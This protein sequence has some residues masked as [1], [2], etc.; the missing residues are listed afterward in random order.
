MKSVLC[1]T[2]GARR[3]IRMV[4]I[5]SSSQPAVPAPPVVHCRSA[6]TGGP[7]LRPGDWELNA[8]ASSAA[9]P[10][11]DPPRPSRSACH[12][13]PPTLSV[14]LS[15]RFQGSSTRISLIAPTG[16][17]PTLLPY[18]FSGGVYRTWCFCSWLVDEEQEADCRLAPERGWA[19]GPEVHRGEFPKA[20]E[21]VGVRCSPI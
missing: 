11:G 8:R 3:G 10:K 12:G 15:P 19:S 17:R 6:A 5:T 9:S 18:R 1:A 16:F 14:E 2:R 7:D 21:R 13:P 4:G 20:T